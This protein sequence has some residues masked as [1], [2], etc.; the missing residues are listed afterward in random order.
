MEAV[1]ASEKLQKVK[2]DRI[3]AFVKLQKAR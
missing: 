2:M 1:G 3:V